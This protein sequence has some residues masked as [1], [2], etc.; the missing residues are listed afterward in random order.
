M[1]SSDKPWYTVLEPCLALLE[2][3]D[4]STALQAVTGRSGVLVTVL[5]RYRALT[6]MTQSLLLRETFVKCEKFMSSASA[7][8]C[9]C[10]RSLSRQ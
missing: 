8:A 1:L 6:Y 4:S 9:Q 7:T 3:Y 2:S 10:S 5:G